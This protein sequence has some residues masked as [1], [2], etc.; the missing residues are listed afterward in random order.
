MSP[1]AG[2]MIPLATFFFDV[3]SANMGNDPLMMRLS[4]EAFRG[5]LFNVRDDQ[6]SGVVGVMWGE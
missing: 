2:I 6:P 4:T 1:P 5:S 3:F